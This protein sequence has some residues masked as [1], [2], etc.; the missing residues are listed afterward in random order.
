MFTL[1]SILA[2]NGT[3][4]IFSYYILQSL[5]FGKENNSKNNSDP[6]ELHRIFPNYHS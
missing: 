2:N 6:S 5:L 1:N 3:Y 4:V